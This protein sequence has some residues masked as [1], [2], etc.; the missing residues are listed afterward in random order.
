[1][2]RVEFDGACG[3]EI[4][5]KSEFKDNVEPGIDRIWWFIR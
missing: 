2:R 3:N 1:M 5:R 4:G